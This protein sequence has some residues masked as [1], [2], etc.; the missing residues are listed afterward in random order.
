MDLLAHAPAF[1]TADARHLARELYGVTA[2][3]RPLTSERDQNFHLRSSNGDEFVLKIANSLEDARFLD[4]QREAMDARAARS[5]FCPRVLPLA[6]GRWAGEAQAPSGARHAVRLVTFIPGTPAGD[7]HY[8][9]AAYR[10]DLGRS[11]GALD[12][13]LE[14][15][16]H[17]A[18]HRE[19]HWDLA[20]G[21]DTC[22]AHLVLVRDATMRELVA[23]LVD[24][25][26]RD[27]TPLLR[28]LPRSVI[29]NDAN[30]F[31]II[32]CDDGDLLHKHQR[33]AGI[34]D[35][36]DMVHSYTVGDLAVAAAYAA[37]GARDPLAAAAEVVAGYH[38]ERAL[39]DAEL[40]ALF[41]LI[42]LRLCTSV[43]MA[44]VQMQQ[45][46][47]DVYLAVSQAPI[48]RALPILA[49]VNPRFAEATFRHACTDA[50]ARRL[51]VRRCSRSSR[52]TRH[53]SRGCSANP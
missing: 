13:A 47:D 37:L 21:V 3:A 52:R 10:R 8:H 19:F 38:P 5:P 4:A 2:T 28:S 44:A 42:R 6:D 22:R 18:T 46:P 40:G 26:D 15:F 12:G 53:A 51:V 48:A 50:T 39:G 17:P 16:D 29:H 30:D 49:R 43:V 33:V 45:R 41:G 25:F 27:M 20:R 35:F 11:V 7:V 14:G 9:S 32:V 31:N 34:I 36:G 1:T 24:A 23:T